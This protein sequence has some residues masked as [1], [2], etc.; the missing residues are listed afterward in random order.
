MSDFKREAK[1]SSPKSSPKSSYEHYH[2]MDSGT[3]I[4]PVSSTSIDED[5]FSK[6]LFKGSSKSI[7]SSSS[8]SSKNWVDSG[9]GIDSGYSVDSGSNVHITSERDIICEDEEDDIAISKATS[10]TTTTPTPTS[11]RRESSPTTLKRTDTT[12]QQQQQRELSPTQLRNLLINSFQ[13]DQDGDTLLHL[14]VIEGKTDMAFTLIRMAP[15]PDFLDIC[16]HLCQTPLHLA[17]LTRQPRIM[18]QLLIAGASL[19]LRDRHGN[20]AL[21]IAAA[22]GH[23]DGVKSL[24]NP[25]T[26]KEVHE[27]ALL[28]YRILIQTVSRDI[29]HLKNYEGHTPVHL[30]TMAE[31]KKTIELLTQFGANI[32]TREGKSGKTPLHW[33]VEY[34]KCDLVQFLLKK[35]RANINVKSYAGHTPLYL[36]WSLLQ[37]YPN[38]SRLKSLVQFLK[39]NGGEPAVAPIDSESEMRTDSEEEDNE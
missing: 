32:N 29:F 14:A 6:D 33:A 17:A 10:K 3:S 37:I 34:Q 16:N 9:L 2:M 21:H 26:D 13:Q 24:L 28:N 5:Q 15:H 35:C 11:T 31:S 23:V 18:R 30:A 7:Q 27:A 22:N 4:G 39:E 20:T 25:V 38:S 19:D 36:A 12:Q 1:S 8:V